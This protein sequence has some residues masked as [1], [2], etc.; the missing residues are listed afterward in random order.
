MSGAPAVAAILVTGASGFVGGFLLEALSKHYPNS[1][2]VGTGLAPPEGSELIHL[3]VTDAE[4]VRDLVRRLRPDV[5]IHLAALASVDQSYGEARAVWDI[6]LGGTLNVAEAIRDLV[7]TCRLVH[8]SSGEIYGLSFLNGEPAHE[9]TA[10]APANPYAVTKAAADLALGEMA[11]HDLHVVR[12]RLFN[13]TGPGQ[14]ERFVLPRFAA[15]VARIAA[16]VQ[17]PIIHTGALD[18]WRD[19]LDVRDVIDAYLAAIS[20]PED[21]FAVNIC[22]GVARR[23]GDIL[24]DLM[25]LAGVRAEVIEQVSEVRRTD[26]RTAVGSPKRAAEALG[27]HPRIAWQNTLSS[28]L[29][30]WRTCVTD[31]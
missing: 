24:H 25:Q 6:N 31:S 7:P 22:S 17:Q 10:L 14:T 18:R 11:L 16:G 2:I 12:L 19:F 26:V 21:G 28:L 20:G 5:C 9:A 30:Y 13:H 4:A 3:D 8:A 27:W 1:R 23:V 29:S 15:Q